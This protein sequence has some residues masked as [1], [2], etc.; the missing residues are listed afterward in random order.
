MNEFAIAISDLYKNTRC[1][2]FYAK[3]FLHQATISLASL[4]HLHQHF[5]K[6]YGNLRDNAYMT[7]FSPILYASKGLQMLGRELAG[8]NWITCVVQKD[9]DLD[10]YFSDHF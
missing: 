7:V 4:L 3:D 9:T 5:L 10:R 8:A 1:E 6:C 2:Y